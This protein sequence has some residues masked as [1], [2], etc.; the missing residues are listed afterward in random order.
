LSEEILKVGD[1]GEIYTNDALRRKVGIRKGGK[2]KAVVAGDR[3][4]I[5]PLPSLED[6]IR[7]SF[8]KLTPKEAE[9]LSEEAQEESGAYG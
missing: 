3:V 1:R 4:V 6:V 2:V 9:R 5:E 7:T 8:V